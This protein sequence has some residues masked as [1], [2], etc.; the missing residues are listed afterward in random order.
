MKFPVI[1]LCV[2]EL[3][4]FNY[5]MLTSTLSLF[6]TNIWSLILDMKISHL[7]NK[8][9]TEKESHSEK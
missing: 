9:N 1:N 8:R 7:K 3:N 4:G 2:P 6:N 5:L